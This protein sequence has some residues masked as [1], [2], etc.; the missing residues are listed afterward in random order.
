MTR[1]GRYGLD[2]VF[3]TVRTDFL[4]PVRSWTD[5][6]ELDDTGAAAVVE[7]GGDVGPRLSR[8]LAGRAC[9]NTG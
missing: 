7:L 8:Y 5:R 1:L 2:H 6:T 4:A 3:H 9:A